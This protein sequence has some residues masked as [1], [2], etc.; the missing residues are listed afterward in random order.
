MPPPRPVQRTSHV[1][2]S[3]SAAAAAA[4]SAAGADGSADGLQEYRGPAQ[5]TDVQ[6]EDIL[7]I[8][9]AIDPMRNSVHNRPV[10]QQYLQ[11]VFT[12]VGNSQVTNLI[13][14]L[15]EDGRLTPGPDPEYNNQ[16]VIDLVNTHLQSSAPSHTASP[17]ATPSTSSTY[18]SPRDQ[19]PMGFT[20][21]MKGSAGNMCSARG[22]P[23]QSKRATTS[24]PT[25]PKPHKKARLHTTPELPS[26]LVPRILKL[27]GPKKHPVNNYCK[28][29]QTGG[30]V[31]PTIP[32]GG[33]NPGKLLW[34]CKM[35]KQAQRNHGAAA[36]GHFYVAIDLREALQQLTSEA[37]EVLSLVLQFLQPDDDDDDD[38]LATFD[39]DDWPDYGN[40]GRDMGPGGGGGMGSNNGWGMGGAGIAS[41]GSRGSRGR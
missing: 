11:Q 27:F 17:A 35:C 32:S 38:D 2:A 19:F 28:V 6:V 15:K 4:A 12:G 14:Q 37:Q 29:G 41:G 30:N 1:R 16:P 31:Y 33:L 25:M 40:G 8:V 21:G 22:Q 23:S 18:T 10:V 39:G 20:Y 13:R 7:Y 36:V 26:W 24:L 34:H 3:T 5:L 9:A